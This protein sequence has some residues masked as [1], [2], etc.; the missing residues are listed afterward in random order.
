MVAK[1][2][3]MHMAEWDRYLEERLPEMQEAMY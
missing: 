3:L 2:I 1:E